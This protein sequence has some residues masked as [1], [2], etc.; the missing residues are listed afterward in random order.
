VDEVVLRSVANR[1]KRGEKE[2]TSGA[3]KEEEGE[4]LGFS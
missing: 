4:R 3:G 2:A 1:R